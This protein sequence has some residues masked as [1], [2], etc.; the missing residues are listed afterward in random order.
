MRLIY[1][2]L[3]KVMMVFEKYWKNTLFLFS[4]LAKLLMPFDIPEVEETED[5]L[6]SNSSSEAVLL[7][8]LACHE[9]ARGLNS[10]PRVEE[11]AESTD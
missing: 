7:L 9:V 8:S 5:I 4:W 6:L 3:R 11:E 2:F 1:L 10:P